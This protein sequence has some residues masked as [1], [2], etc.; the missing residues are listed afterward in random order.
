[1]GRADSCDILT[2]GAD[3]LVGYEA[4]ARGL[5]VAAGDQTEDAWFS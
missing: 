3:A 2:Q 5:A 1:M 4:D